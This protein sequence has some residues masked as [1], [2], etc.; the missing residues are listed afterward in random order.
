LRQRPALGI[1][2]T[3]LERPFEERRN[4]LIEDGVAELFLALEVVVEVALADA[5]LTQH[6][7][8]R[9]LVVPVDVDQPGRGFQDRLPVDRPS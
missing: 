8:E 5:A 7:I 6:V 1:R 2:E 3:G 9:G 4:H